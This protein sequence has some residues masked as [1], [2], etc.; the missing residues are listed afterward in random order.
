MT[1]RHTLTTSL[2]LLVIGAGSTAQASGFQLREQSPAAQGNAFA[3][4]TAKG[5]DISAMFFNPATMTEFEGTQAV[6]G[7]SFVAPKAELSNAKATRASYTGPLAGLSPFGGTSIHGPASHGNAAASAVLPNLYAMWSF[8]DK[9]KLGLSVNAPFGMV[10]EYDDN[11]VGRY[12]ALKS[13]LKVVDIAF[14]AAY[15]VTPKLSLGAALIYRTVEAELSNA[16]DFGQIAFL[17]LAQAGSLGTAM[18]FQPSS[19]ASNFDGKSTIKGKTAL[20]AFKLGLTYKP[21]AAVTLGLAHQGS[22]AVRLDGSISYTY[23]TIANPSLAGAMNLVT[24]NA[25]LV[26]GPVSSAVTLPST[27]SFGL[28]WDA[29]P[30]LNLAFEASRTDW[31]SFEELRMKFGSGQSDSVT[32]EHWKATMYLSLGASWKVNDAWTLR[33]GLATDQGAVEEKY[34]TPRIPDSDRIWFS[35]GL[36]YTLSKRLA[37]DFGLTHIQ[38]KESK[39]ALSAGNYGNPDFFRGT[40]SGTYNNSVDIAALSLRYSF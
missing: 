30:A 8:D 27:T 26:N 21:T 11:F 36:S 24:M 6:A 1:L 17:G 3:G 33:A 38:V 23:P 18:N 20:P 32:E 12:H 5:F 14:N 4:V 28:A 22:S 40:L 34:R 15:R 25:K 19:T 39:L 29:T 37:V 13:D 31:A 10:T 7:F 35:A 2:A 16:V 9:V